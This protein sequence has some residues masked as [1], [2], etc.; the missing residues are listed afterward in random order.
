MSLS[1]LKPPRASLTLGNLAPTHL[2]KTLLLCNPWSCPQINWDINAT[3]QLKLWL[4]QVT[5]VIA[6]TR[7]KKI[8]CW[9]KWTQESNLEHKS[10]FTFISSKI[11]GVTQSLTQWWRAG[12]GAFNHCEID[13]CIN[14]QPQNLYRID[15][16]ENNFNKVKIEWKKKKEILFVP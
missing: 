3:L 15:A 10:P 13:Q 9:L 11:G 7:Y 8:C 5:L 1:C 6:R 2:P 16:G 14:S 12:S 4:V